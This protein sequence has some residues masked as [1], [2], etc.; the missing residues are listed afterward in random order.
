MPVAYSTDLRTRVIDTWNA[1]EGTQAQLAERFKVSLSFVKRVLH[2][3]RTSAQR[4]AKPRGATLAP[5]I[6]G[7]ALIL[8]QRLIEHKPDITLEELSEQLEK[9]TQIKVSK[10]TMCRAVQRLK[11]PRKKKHCMPLSKILLVFASSGMIT[12]AGTSQVDVRNLIFIDEA[13]IHLGMV[14]LFGRALRGE[15][16]VDSVPRN[17]GT[18]VSLIGALS[19]DGL[20][21]SMTLSGSVDTAVFL[22]Y[23]NEVLVP[24][25]WTGAIV[26][27]DNLKV[28]HAHSVRSA[29]E[30]V[31]DTDSIFAALFTRLVSHRVVLVETQAILAFQSCPYLRGP[32]PSND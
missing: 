18:N 26:V 6:N 25:L 9:R 17:R 32:R 14:R 31:G 19:L 11:M 28:H 13:G 3:Y 23:V 27:M 10:P 21:A 15:R 1:K 8:V 20:I 22:S 2:R 24:Q 30:A 5:T 4:E 7:E 29:I 16:A 12:V